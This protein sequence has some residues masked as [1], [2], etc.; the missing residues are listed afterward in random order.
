MGTNETFIFVYYL[1]IKLWFAEPVY[2]KNSPPKVKPSGEM[3]NI[4]WLE[5]FSINSEVKE[6]ILY[7]DGV[8]EY[9]GLS[10]N[11]D[12]KRQSKYQSQSGLHIILCGAKFTFKVL[13]FYVDHGDQRDFSQLFSVLVS[14][15]CFI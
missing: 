5:S 10:T 2:N 14:S 9:S 12:V 4:D 11:R 1:L 3:V 13:F 8:V 15:F 7:K 6:F